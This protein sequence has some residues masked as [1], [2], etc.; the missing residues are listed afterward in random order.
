MAI[1]L[2]VIKP[3]TFICHQSKK[4]FM[5]KY[6]LLFV[7]LTDCKQ[8]KNVLK[9]VTIFVEQYK[10][11]GSDLDFLEE[12]IKTIAP[13]AE[14]NREVQDGQLKYKHSYQVSVFDN[15][16]LYNLIDSFNSKSFYFYRLCPGIIDLY[17][18]KLTSREKD[19]IQFIMLKVKERVV[20]NSYK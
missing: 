3:L 12:Q 17:K 7:L 18:D 8:E 20:Q 4:M 6:L 11:C 2:T 9:E 19:S 10:Q 5:K 15:K 13:D 14:K 1:Y 16:K